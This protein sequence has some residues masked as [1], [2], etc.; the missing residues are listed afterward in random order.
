MTLN[1]S[2]NMTPQHVTWGE[3]ILGYLSAS[4]RH[5]KAVDDREY[6]MH[7]M[8]IY[9]I[10]VIHILSIFILYIYLYTSWYIRSSAYYVEALSAQHGR[11]KWVDNGL[12]HATIGSASVPKIGRAKRL[13]LVSTH[14]A[15]HSDPKAPKV[16]YF[17]NKMIHWPSFLLPGSSNN[18]KVE[19]LQ[20]SW[21]QFRWQTETAQLQNHSSMTCWNR[22]LRFF[23]WKPPKAK[24]AKKKTV[25]DRPVFFPFS[26]PVP[27][28]P[29]APRTA[30]WRGQRTWPGPQRPSSGKRHCN[31]NVVS[32][33]FLFN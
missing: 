33:Q 6:V 22:P 32:I 7:F 3:T 23:P 16:M 5:D 10:Y 17:V 15:N 19:L 21:P 2:P 9:V 25:F 1:V 28:D 30:E 24:D 18:S 12:Q 26:A 29:T 14:G 13:A 20:L 11:S 31:S 8:F 4:D 27:W